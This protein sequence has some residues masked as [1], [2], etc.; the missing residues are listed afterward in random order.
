MSC[1]ARTTIQSERM[2]SMI[3]ECTLLEASFEEENLSVR[4]VPNTSTLLSMLSTFNQYSN[5]YM[6]NIRTHYY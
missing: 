1:R 5:H 6:N 3:T 4:I 2:Q